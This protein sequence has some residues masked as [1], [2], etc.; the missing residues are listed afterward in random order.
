MMDTIIQSLTNFVV[1]HQRVVDAFV[2]SIL[3]IASLQN[4]IYLLQIPVAWWAL[5]RYSLASDTEI[6]WQTL[7]SDTTLP[8]TVIVPAHNEETVIV[9]SVRG[10][11]GLQYPEF[12]VIVVNDGSDD[13]TLDVLIK[14]YDLKE[15]TRAYDETL[16]HEPIRAIYGSTIYSNLVVVDKASGYC[17]A[18][19]IN[20]GINVSRLPLFC[21]VD[22]DSLLDSGA[23]LRA[24][25][26]F[27][28]DPLRMVA[29]GGTIRV[30]NGC[31][32]RMGLV[33]KIKL[34]GRFLPLA[35]T[36][37]Y[38]RAFLMAR[39]AFSQW[40]ILL[41]ISGA[42]GVF[43]RDPVVEAGGYSKNTVGEDMELIVKLHHYLCDQ[44]RDYAMRY[45]AEPVCWT[46][47][48]ETLALLSLQRTRWQRGA[49]ESFFKHIKMFLN[50]RYGKIGMLGYPYSFLADVLSPLAEVTGYFLLTIFY[51]ID[52]IDASFYFAF[53][54]LVVFYGI[55]ISAMAL[56][57]EEE[58]LWSFPRT[59]DLAQLFF[60]SVI[61]NFG[62]RQ[63]NNV[64]RV[65][66]LWQFLWKK[67]GW[68]PMQRQAFQS[69]PKSN[70]SN[71]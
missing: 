67:K 50:P 55:F 68:G 7:L 53:T 22:A 51:L 70:D 66:G 16:S 40:D 42:F 8:V 1:L 3:G 59:R 11:L 45:V 2:W 34:P 64:W 10:L 9:E 30:V 41:I 71:G 47:V 31:E 56:I 48:P 32:T 69:A 5:R 54:G 65:I 33:Q 57:L 38:I 46:Q 44:K 24:V 14:A 6:S 60:I 21:V 39:T 18:D 61:E 43:R 13:A 62:Y 26:P 4:L 25:R 49:L 52:A 29:V 27:I 28:E 63:I 19:A 36:M 23:L 58:E 35:Q 15:K 37:E 12:E 17:K 20:A